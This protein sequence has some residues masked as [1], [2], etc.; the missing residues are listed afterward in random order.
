M[1]QK[2]F[3]NKKKSKEASKDKKKRER[4][5]TETY[6]GGRGTKRELNRKKHKGGHYKGTRKNKAKLGK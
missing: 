2:K 4:I 3:I 5:I 1:G 6:K